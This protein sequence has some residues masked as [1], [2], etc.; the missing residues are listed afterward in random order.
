MSADGGS[1]PFRFCVATGGTRTA[2]EWR[3]LT[4][5]VEGTG[6]DLLAMTDHIHQRLAPFTSLAMAAAA[7]TTL[8][9]GT[10]V[11]CH[12]LRNPVV[13]AKEFATLDALS[14][15]RA[16]IG[17]GA[18]WR[19]SDYTR[20]GIPFGTRPQRFERFV[21]YVDVICALLA[22]GSVAY[23][24][25]YL[26]VSDVTSVPSPANPIP[27]LIGGSRRRLIELAARRADTVSIAPSR[28]PDG[29]RS[30]YWDAEIDERIRWVQTAA[31]GRSGRPEIDLA[32]HECHV[33]PHPG[34]AIT[35]LSAAFGIREDQLDAI[36]SLLVGSPERITEVLLARRE[37]WGATRVTI[38]D[39][40]LDAMAPVV[41]RLAG[42]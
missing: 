3:E 40:A 4:R 10:Y 29:R 36:P 26:S 9:L 25:S 13:L 5:K 19:R 8:R 22:G 35:R 31:A 11:M 16:E 2:H 17:L 20:T 27:L 6:Y 18:G 39:T 21:E 32:I 30:T 34:A 42:T 7:T 12:D 33:L 24:G 37:R 1:A 23:E 14:G 41:A 38:P 15:G 28:H